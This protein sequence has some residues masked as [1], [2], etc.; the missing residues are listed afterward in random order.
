MGGSTHHTLGLCLHPAGRV[1]ASVWVQISRTRKGRSTFPTPWVSS[2][3][4]PLPDQPQRAPAPGQSPGSGQP[5]SS[6]HGACSLHVHHRDHRAWPCLG[7]G[8]Q[9]G[10]VS[11]SR[12]QRQGGT[13]QV[14]KRQ[15]PY[16]TRQ[17]QRTWGPSSSSSSAVGGSWGAHPERDPGAQALAMS[18]PPTSGRVGQGPSV[19]PISR[20]DLFSSSPR[21]SRQKLTTMRVNNIAW[22]RTGQGQRAP[23][24]PCGGSRAH[25]PLLLQVTL[26]PIQEGSRAEARLPKRHGAQGFSAPISPRQRL[27]LGPRVSRPRP[28]G[29]HLPTT[30]TQ[31]W[32]PHGDPDPAPRLSGL[33]WEGPG[34]QA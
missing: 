13:Y 33:G 27:P 2:D 15:L 12:V 6:Q 34:S 18:P 29:P 11:L 9:Q 1:C 20:K 17:V 23:R 21:D 16:R 14:T 26:L 31:P 8:G 3:S 4:T 10:A 22:D 19:R 25:Q 24:G 32:R 30:R 28:A 5:E 7:A